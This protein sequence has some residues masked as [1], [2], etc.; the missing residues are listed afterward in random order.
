MDKLQPWEQP[1]TPRGREI[2][3]Q[4]GQQTFGENFM[5]GVRSTAAAAG[6]RVVRDEAQP[7]AEDLYPGHTELF[8]Q[9]A[10]LAEGLKADG[11]QI[12]SGMLALV[13]VRG[14]EDD[15]DVAEK[16]DEL[17]TGIPFHLHDE[18]VSNTNYGAATRA[19]QRILDTLDRGQRMGLQ[20]GASPVLAH[21]AGSMVDVDLPLTFATGG[22]FGAARVARAGV[23][24]SA[25]LGLST[26]AAQRTSSALIGA[27]AGLQAG[28]ASGV[29]LKA[30]DDTADWTVIAEQGLAGAL[31]GGTL[32]GVLRGDLGL[33]IKAAQD[34]LHSRMSRDA[35]EL[36]RTADVN[37]LAIKGIEMPVATADGVDVV[38]TPGQ[39]DPGAAV[40]GGT[41][42]A[43]RTPG[44]LDSATRD[45]LETLASPAERDVTLASEDWVTSTGWH[46][47][48]VDATEERLYSYVV[49]GIAGKTA[50]DYNNLLKSKS[51]TAGF[52][53]GGVFES[54]HGFGRGRAT[55]A[56]LSEQY[57]KQIMEPVI[58]S[59]EV[60]N[61][62]AQMT[63]QTFIPG[64][65]VGGA[66]SK[67]AG[68]SQS[69][70]AMFG[71]EVKL[72]INRRKIGKSKAPVT[73]EEKLIHQAADLIGNDASGRALS[74]AQGR[75]GEKGV[76]GWDQIQKGPYDTYTWQ[77]RVLRDWLRTG[78][79]HKDTLVEDLANGYQSAGF[80]GPPG[81][82][83]STVARAIAQALVTRMEA[84]SEGVSMSLRDILHSDGRAF[85][86]KM[87]RDSG[88]D[89]LQIKSI[90]ERIS[91]VK[92]E[93][94]K[95]ASAKYRNDIDLEMPIRT[96]DG[97]T[98]QVIDLMDTDIYGSWN[99]Y[100]RQ[101]GGSSGLARM[102]IT[103]RAQ[104]ETMITA[105][106]KEQLALGEEPID[107]QVMRAMLT[108]FDGGPIHGVFMGRTT[109]GLGPAAAIAKRL[110][111]VSLLQG[112]GFAQIA[113]TGAVAN[114]TGLANF[115]DRGV[116]G[117]VSKMSRDQQ[118]KTLRDIEFI[119][120]RIGEDH[121][122]L[123]PHLELDTV[124]RADVSESLTNFQQMLGKAQWLNGYTSLFNSVRSWQQTT[125]AL[126][127]MDKIIQQGL[128][129]VD[130]KRVGWT[131][132]Q[133]FRLD[134]DFGIDRADA[135]RVIDMVDQG[136]IT[137]RPNAFGGIS[138]D[139]LN[140]DQWDQNVADVFGAGVTRSVNQQV[141]KS[142]AGEADVWM[143]N[144]AMN[145][146]MQFKS[147]PMQAVSKQAARHLRFMDMETYGALGFGMMT[148]YTSLYLRD[149]AYGRERSTYERAKAA[150]GYSNMT[151]FVPMVAD[152]M[153]SMVGLEDKRFNQFGQFWEQAIPAVDT[154]N[155]LIRVPGAIFG[156]LPDGEYNKA[157]Q[158]ALKAL[159]F[160][161]MPVWS[162][163]AWD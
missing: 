70:Q 72:E 94:G 71:R 115:I 60:M 62:W 47:R 135:M 12:M 131:D 61:K 13:G 1:G 119:T 80:A 4:E 9:T 29:G 92:E 68:V 152:P 108:H 86:E 58:R 145:I 7:L 121:K 98:A 112:L 19:R 3:E 130:G 28:V 81:K 35:P 124:G 103:N 162:A 48:K 31:L 109:E 88:V 144:E 155:R 59:Q 27:N 41:V 55:S 33:Q 101:V 49:E 40:T 84:S 126:G 51:P 150:V 117:R 30:W 107:P 39:P 114:A 17:T 132:A 163:I 44:V 53:A 25:G 157:D 160:M 6:I 148:A 133:L 16:Y 87:L 21:M 15:Y 54:P 57:T 10:D 153:L 82:D 2:A 127:M 11:R 5:E 77:G 137:T 45:R 37:D 116:L 20:R 96:T 76:D 93:A 50:M 95:L 32:N 142:M 113:E 161:N 146:L 73:E 141:Q 26:R 43:A 63:R 134:Q 154:F 89:D 97:S 23:R 38:V 67:G 122:F 120:G 151:G 83:T 99:R 24:V 46:D 90:I 52:F 22:G 125:V 91:G 69:G 75:A 74:I 8:E 118:V 65:K 139:R 102:G 36:N 64:M 34:D 159:P 129:E 136:F 156:G 140:M 123:A 138:V 104:R 100:A 143:N 149:V 78:K 56:I 110:T 85:L 158:S 14:G 105:M 18:I 42:N 106:N 147:F 111:S 66:E 128:R 79:V